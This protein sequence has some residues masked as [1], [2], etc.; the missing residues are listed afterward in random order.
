M[1]VTLHVQPITDVEDSTQYL[2]LANGN[3]VSMM[4]LLGIEDYRDQDDCLAGEFTGDRLNHLV[5]QIAF[6]LDSLV[7]M[8]ELDNGS[9]TVESTGMRGCKLIELGKRPGYW[10]D[11]LLRLTIFALE[12]QRTKKPLRY[13]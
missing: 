1:S 8:P 3:F 13:Y 9:A 2:N 12:A 7:A 5:D 11:V 10:Q 4:E 6:V